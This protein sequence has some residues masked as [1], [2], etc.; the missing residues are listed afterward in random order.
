MNPHLAYFW[1]CYSDMLTERDLKIKTV[2]AATEI[3]QSRLYAFKNAKQIPSLDNA[4]KLAA[5][6]DCSLDFL[7]GFT[8]ICSPPAANYS[9]DVSDRVKT[10]MDASNITRYRLFKNTD[11]SQVQ[12][13]RWYHGIQ[14]PA[15]GS[16]VV[17]ADALEC[18]LDYL[19]GADTNTP[20]TLFR[21]TLDNC[22]KL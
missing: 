3:A 1:D 19:A 22:G 12:L 7:F 5:Y 21:K 4:L 9:A 10:A 14:T 11:I 2:S 13:Y 17:L 18:S 20:Y 8:E 15:L 6:F 16:L